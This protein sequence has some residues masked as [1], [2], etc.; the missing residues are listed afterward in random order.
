MTKYIKIEVIVTGAV[1]FLG[2]DLEEGQTLS[3]SDIYS[4]VSTVC[5]ILIDDVFYTLS[6]LEVDCERL[7]VLVEELL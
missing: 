7:Y 1:L 6:D 2:I 3:S 5:P 4:I